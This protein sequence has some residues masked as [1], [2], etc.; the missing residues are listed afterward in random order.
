MKITCT[1][2]LNMDNSLRLHEEQNT[3]GT[4]KELQIIEGALAEWLCSGLQ[5]R[6]PRF[7]SGTRLHLTSH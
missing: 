6:G 3:S 2:E 1:K 4:S 7:D 5:I